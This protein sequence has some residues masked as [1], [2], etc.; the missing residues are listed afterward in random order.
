VTLQVDA[1]PRRGTGPGLK[2]RTIAQPHNQNI[3][4]V[5]IF[6][7]GLEKLLD[8]IG[9]E[10]RDRSN[11]E[12]R[13]GAINVLCERLS[14]RTGEKAEKFARR[15]FDYRNGRSRAV[16]ADTV[17]LYYSVCGEQYSHPGNEMP[18]FPAG[19]PAAI[20]MVETWCPELDEDEKMALAQK[21]IHIGE[22]LCLGWDVI[23][24]EIC[25]SLELLFRG[26]K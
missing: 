17:D 5:S 21:M 7:I 10:L 14:A 25:N 6:H 2:R 4:P 26:D 16:T 9:R 23:D 11:G 3:V 8:K 18:E 15:I 19:M 13:E 22:G 20:E 1:R 12:E 24:L